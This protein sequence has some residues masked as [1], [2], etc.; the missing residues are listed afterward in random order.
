MVSTLKL[1]S[2]FCHC[3]L[4]VCKADDVSGLLSNQFC[5]IFSTYS[6]ALFSCNVVC[7]G[8]SN[9]KRARQNKTARRNAK[10]ECHHMGSWLAKSPI[11]FKS[12]RCPSVSSDN[13]VCSE[14]EKPGISA[15]AKMYAVCLWYAVWAMSMPISCNNAA[16]RT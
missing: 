13:K 14:R 1:R 11:F 16:Q 9:G 4:S 6:P 7:G 5:E 8:N 10:M 12:P 3:S 15:C 2:N